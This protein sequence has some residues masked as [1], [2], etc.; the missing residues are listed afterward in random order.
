MNNETQDGEIDPILLEMSRIRRMERGKI[1]RMNNRPHYNHQTWREGKNVV[2]YVPAD[3]VESLQDAIDG[4]R[5]FM[6]LA[7]AYAQKVILRTRE[8]ASK[9]DGSG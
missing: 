3:Q 6:E 9:T 7:E 4:Y 2:R 1:C 8:E 5:R